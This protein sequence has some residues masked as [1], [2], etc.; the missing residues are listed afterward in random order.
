MICTLFSVPPI[1]RRYW[2]PA[3]LARAMVVELQM[4]MLTIPMHYVGK[5]GRRRVTFSVL[6]EIIHTYPEETNLAHNY[7]LTFTI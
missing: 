4:R 1:I 2:F 3:E 5:F 7:E 6:L